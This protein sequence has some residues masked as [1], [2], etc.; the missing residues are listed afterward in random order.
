MSSW[1]CLGVTSWGHVVGTCCGGMSWGHVVGA[2]RGV[3]RGDMSV[4][5][6]TPRGWMP[7]LNFFIDHEVVASRFVVFLLFLLCRILSPIPAGSC[8]LHYTCFSCFIFVLFCFVLFF[9]WFYFCFCFCFCFIYIMERWQ[10]TGTSWMFSEA[11]AFNQD[12]TRLIYIRLFWFALW[13]H[14]LL[15]FFCFCCAGFLLRSLQV[16]VR[17]FA[18]FY[19]CFVLVLFLS[20][21]LFLFLLFL[22]LLLLLLLPLF[23]FVFAFAFTF[24]LSNRTLAKY[25]HELDILWSERL[26]PGQN[27]VNLH[28]SVLLF[29]LYIYIFVLIFLYLLLLLLLHFTL[30]NLNVVKV[31]AP[32]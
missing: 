27:Q 32:G 13:P 21:S 19:F 30:V 5:V 10:R 14:V 8:L 16:H 2:C 28:P 23:A 20:L 25:R 4:C 24:T 18:L 1:V 26:Q 9:F 17:L 7:N 15:C 6:G 12:K 31:P 11:N 29:F 3:C 22:L